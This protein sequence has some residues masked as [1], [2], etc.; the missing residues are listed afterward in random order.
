M[1]LNNLFSGVERSEAVAKGADVVIMAVNAV[2]GWTAKDA[3][4]L[5]RIGNKVSQAF[6]LL[7]LFLLSN[8]LHLDE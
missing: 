7:S 5:S 4:L 1:L 2:D 6:L 3:E 8:F